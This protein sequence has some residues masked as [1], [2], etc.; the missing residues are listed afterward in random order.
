M[1]ATPSTRERAV[2][3]PCK[4]LLS[5]VEA[6]GVCGVSPSTFDRMMADGLMPR[7]KRVYARVLWDLVALNA[8]IDALPGDPDM[9]DADDPETNEWD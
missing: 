7:P 6:A 1:T 8:A 5:R 2:P 3:L 4:R 9:P